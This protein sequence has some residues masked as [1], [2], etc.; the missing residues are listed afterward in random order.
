MNGTGC[1]EYYATDGVFQL[2]NEG[3]CDTSLIGFYVFGLFIAGT[4]LVGAMKHGFNWYYTTRQVKATRKRNLPLGPMNSLIQALF[5]LMQVFLYAFDVVNM[6]NGTSLSVYSAIFLP[7]AWWFTVYLLRL[8]KLGDKILPKAQRT[9]DHGRELNKFDGLGKFML[10]IQVFSLL[11]SSFLLIVLGPIIP[12]YEVLMGRIG[13]GFKASFIL[14]CA[15]GIIYQFQRCIKAV[16]KVR[17]N[18]KLERH[19]DDIEV[20]RAV[21]RMR[22]QQVLAFFFGFPPGLLY[23]LL[24]LISEIPWNIFILLVPHA[25]ESLGTFLVECFLKVHAKQIKTNAHGVMMSSPAP[26][27]PSGRNLGEA[28]IIYSQS[29]SQPNF[30]PNNATSTTLVFDEISSG[31]RRESSQKDTEE[32]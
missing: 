13:F 10:A 20:I 2:P 30:S 23:L 32:S 1:P 12:E 28:L 7:F 17:D 24:S 18:V 25:F 3:S 5:Y 15:A 19:R 9:H 6:R 29:S 16:E 26:A 11:V 31:L 14:F 4:R 21:K 22:A 8:V 27:S